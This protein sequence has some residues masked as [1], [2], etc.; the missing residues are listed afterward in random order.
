MTRR[1]YSDKISI[2]S[3]QGYY[4]LLPIG[5]HR[6]RFEA[7]HLKTKLKNVEFM[8]CKSACSTNV[9]TNKTCIASAIGWR[10]SG[11]ALLRTS[12]LR[13]TGDFIM[14]MSC[15][16]YRNSSAT[17]WIIGVR[18]KR[19]SDSHVAVKPVTWQ[20]ETELATCVTAHDKQMLTAGGRPI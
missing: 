3:S 10:R 19:V 9:T 8:A 18:K 5:F 12:S 14:W 6:F 16:V 1:T 15:F 20:K 13:S 7:Y 11:D 17:T 4:C 2:F